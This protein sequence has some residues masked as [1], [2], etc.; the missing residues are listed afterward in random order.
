MATYTQQFGDRQDF[1]HRRV[2]N[3]GISSIDQRLHF[4]T[5]LVEKLVEGQVQQRKTCG[6]CYISN[7]PSNMCPTLQDGLNA[8]VYAVGG[9]PNPSQMRYDSYSNM[10]TQEWRDNLSFSF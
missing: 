3:V 5:F 1:I 7:H 4:L 6:I 8:Q 2:N 9:F 10:Y